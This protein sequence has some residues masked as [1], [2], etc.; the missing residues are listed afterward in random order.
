[1]II[2]EGQGV[3]TGRL[4][5]ITLVMAWSPGL[6]PGAEPARIVFSLALDSQRHPDVAAWL[7]DPHPWPA[8]YE[9]PNQAPLAG[10]VAHDEDGWS[11]R[12]YADAAAAPDAPVH[13]LLN[14]GQ[15]RPGEV[16]T[17]RAP[18]GGEAAWRVVGVG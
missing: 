12:F 4:V 18:G 17:I 1:V 8:R 11:L 2:Q 6:A 15:L 14:P 9:A 10:D 13:R 16:L 5:E 3:D 7:A